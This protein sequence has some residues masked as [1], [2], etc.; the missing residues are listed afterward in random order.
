MA[1]N[2]GNVVAP[3]KSY[4]HGPRLIFICTGF[5]LAALCVG[6]VSAQLLSMP[7]NLNFN[8]ETSFCC[9]IEQL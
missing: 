6:L 7:V 5:F 4:S 2:I 8:P 3:E 1:D 9:R